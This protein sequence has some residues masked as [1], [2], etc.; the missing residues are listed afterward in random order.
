MCED[1]NENILRCSCKRGR[2][3][4]FLIPALLLLLSGKPSHGYELTE[5]YT[6]F[7]FTE[8]GSDPGAIYRTLKLL[9]SEGFI[10]SKWETNE[11]GPAKKIYSITDEGLELLSSWVA[12]IKERKKIFELFLKRY[13]KLK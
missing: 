11:A 13:D 3:S 8:A 10:K 9:D 5:K 7:G 1:N 6:E 4:R 2:M 12:K